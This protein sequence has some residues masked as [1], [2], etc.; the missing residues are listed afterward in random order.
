MSLDSLQLAIEGVNRSGKILNWYSP[1]QLRK[2]QLIKLK[3][4][5]INSTCRKIANAWFEIDFVKI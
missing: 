4:N 5:G 3:A 2:S 1:R